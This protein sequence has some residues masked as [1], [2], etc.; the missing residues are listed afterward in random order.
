VR[1][2]EI[3]PVVARSLSDEDGSRRR[4]IQ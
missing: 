1:V 2:I 4:L 3:L